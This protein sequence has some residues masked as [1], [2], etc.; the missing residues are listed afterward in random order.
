VC[1]QMVSFTS[2]RHSYSRVHMAV[3]QTKCLVMCPHGCS[4]VI[5]LQQHCELWCT[6]PVSAGAPLPS[7]ASAY[8]STTHQMVTPVCLV[9]GLPAVVVWL[10]REGGH[11]T[12]MW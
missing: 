11:A 5:Y 12:Q 9:R 2:G 4:D 3:S 8:A 10:R 1:R 6:T 7:C